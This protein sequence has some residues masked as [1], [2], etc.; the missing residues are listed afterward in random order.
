MSPLSVQFQVRPREV[1]GAHK[2]VN[3]TPDGGDARLTF[4]EASSLLLEGVENSSEGKGVVEL[5]VAVLDTVLVVELR[6]R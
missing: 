6:S 5:L 4:S 3:S 1:S 2:E